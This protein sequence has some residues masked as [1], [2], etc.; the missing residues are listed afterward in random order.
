VWQFYLLCASSIAAVALAA[1]LLES[2]PQLV[3]DGVDWAT[4]L[5]SE[6]PE[7]VLVL[8]VPNQSGVAAVRAAVDPARILAETPEAIVL[9]EGRVVATTPEAVGEPLS[10]AG[11][12]DRSI[13]LWAVRQ[14]SPRTPRE[15]EQ[16]GDEGLSLAALANKPTLTLVEM[17]AILNGQVGGVER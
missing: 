11:L 14:R 12:A 5:G 3:E 13:E 17:L 16:G 7:P 15:R 2:R 6:E 10:E 1:V 8:L 4:S 9:Q